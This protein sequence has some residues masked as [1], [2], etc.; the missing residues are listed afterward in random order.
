LRRMAFVGEIVERAD[1]N[2]RTIAEF[3][4]GTNPRWDYWNSLGG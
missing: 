2:A 3:A 4:I 1:K